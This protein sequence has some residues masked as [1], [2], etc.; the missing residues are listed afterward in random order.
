M[1][2][3]RRTNPRSMR[4]CGRN[5]CRDIP[6]QSLSPPVRPGFQNPKTTEGYFLRGDR[7]WGRTPTWSKPLPTITQTN[8]ANYLFVLDITNLRRRPINRPTV[9]TN[10]EY[11]RPTLSIIVPPLFIIHLSEHHDSFQEATDYQRIIQYHLWWNY[12][13]RN[14]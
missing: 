9:V 14:R 2:M 11:S 8:F 5:C 13:W 6:F 4:G 12:R 10:I 1:A 3:T 7:S